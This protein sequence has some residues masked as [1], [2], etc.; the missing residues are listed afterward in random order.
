MIADV[1]IRLAAPADAAGIA[2]LSRDLIE[3]G[4][5][6]RWRPG[7]VLRAIRDPDTNVV[8]VGAADAI[9][10]FGIMAYRSD[11][12]HLLLLAVRREQQRSGIGSA[13]LGWLE[14]VARVAGARR[15]RVEA[16]RDNAA[17]R[18]FYNQHGYH[19]SFI[20]SA[21]YSGIADGI[22]LEKWLRPNA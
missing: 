14:D 3:Q 13:M 12:A 10:G 21:M 9:T 2:A 11:D 5:P 4:L 19:E 7:R 16:R 22:G 17:A 20:E 15:I 6:W 8:V 18:S 1:A